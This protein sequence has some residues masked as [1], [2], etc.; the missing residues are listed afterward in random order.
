VPL[1]GVTAASAVLRADIKEQG[2]MLTL[3]FFV[4]ARMVEGRGTPPPLFALSEI[5]GCYRSDSGCIED[6]VDENRLRVRGPVHDIRVMLRTEAG[7][8]DVGACAV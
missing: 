8:E 6:G 5:Q 3:T 4:D 2:I 1:P 7:K